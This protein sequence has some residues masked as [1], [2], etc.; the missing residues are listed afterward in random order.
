MGFI[1]AVLGLIA[2]GVGLF[3]AYAATRP[4]EFRIVRSARI[5]APPDRVFALINDLRA[6][7]TW[8]PFD[9]KQ[10]PY[11]KG[12][13][14]GP[15]C[16]VGAH[17]DF[18]SKKAGTGHIEIVEA[19]APS[20]VAMRLLMT[21][22]MACDNRIEFT[23]APHGADSDVTWAMSGKSGF[24]GKLCGLLFN[25]DKMCGGMFEKGLADLKV[26]AEQRKLAA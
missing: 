21:R 9:Q 12:S 8:N 20:H 10:D 11:I 2:V 5:A 3:L 19:E 13:Y 26:V 25:V 16:G 23:I 18:E 22:P 7:N 1:F 17:Y 24:A 6:M 15:Q 14:S 4:D